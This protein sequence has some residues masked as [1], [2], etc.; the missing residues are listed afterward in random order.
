M[1][2]VMAVYIMNRD[3]CRYEGESKEVGGER[4]REGTQHT[5]K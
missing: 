2:V 1:I 3:D 5:L 4:H